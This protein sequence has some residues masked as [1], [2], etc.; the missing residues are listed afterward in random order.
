MDILAK[1]KITRKHLERRAA[2]YVRQSSMHQ[3][4][5]HTTS[6]QLQYDLCH[7][8]AS[9]GWP[10]EECVLYDADLGVS[11]SKPA[12]RQG[13]AQLVTDVALGSIGIIFAFDVTR[14][15][16]NNSDWHRLLD[17]CS[18]CGTLVADLDGIYDVAIYNDRLLLGL[19]GTM[20]EAEHHLIRTR[21]TE[22]MEQRA[23]EGALRKRL[24]VGLAYDPDGK[25]I[26]HPD[27]SIRHAV[28]LVFEKFRELGTAHQ[29]Y[30][31]FQ[32]EGL[33]LPVRRYKWDDIQ[34][35]RPNYD[36]IRDILAN[37]RYAG[38]YVYGRTK[39]VRSVDGHGNVR[40]TRAT[41]P[42][43][44]WKVMLPNHHAGYICW[45]DFEE[46]QKRMRKNVLMSRT[47]EAAEVLRN[48]RG[49]LQGL[50]RCGLCGRRMYTQYPAKGDGVRYVCQKRA[51]STDGEGVCQSF[52]GTRVEE[53]VVEA[54]FDALAPASVQLACKTL[55]RMAT[56]Q[57]AVLQQLQDQLAEARYQA[58]RA[59]RQYDAVEPENRNVART[60]ERAWNE[61]LQRVT[62][63]EAKIARKQQ[64]PPGQLSSEETKRLPTLGLDLRKVWQAPTTEPR[65][66]KRALQLAF[67]CVFARL[68]RATREVNVTLV[69]AGGITTHVGVR[70][71]GVG[72]HTNVTCEEIVNDVRTMAEAGMTDR[73]IANT[74]LRRGDR[75]ATGLPF[76]VARVRALRRKHAIAAAEGRDEPPGGESTLTAKQAAEALGVTIQT[77]LRW[78]HQGLL[79]GQQVTPLAPW[80]IH[81]PETLRF[82]SEESAPAGWLTLREA[83]EQLGGSCDEV[84]R[85]VL[86]GRLPAMLAGVGRQKRL[87]VNVSAVAASSPGP[88]FDRP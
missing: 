30:R 86:A 7:R 33:Q 39:I 18:L 17:M 77:V 16:R 1:T 78:L 65:D 11:G 26:L 10:R 66:R 50:M 27:E 81:L 12:Q 31:Y 40:E 19:K 76:S 71:P 56:Q 45:E 60:L 2:V 85:S 53:A 5:R 51:R 59:R 23:R 37:P 75:T 43:S 8:A 62:E 68:E 32:H 24:P 72:F 22:G 20:S 47:A 52:G 49:V 25:V 44:E 83:A 84:T 46:N 48:G 4:Q 79:R 34:W 36:A 9:F 88:L 80:R 64:M 74:F 63:L 70:V 87:R 38:A 41:M 82:P 35:G 15:A 73:Q 58:A 21:M 6:A 3:V 42:S 13:F 55:E 28:A 14:L 29:V 57:D 67:E 69:W 61:K 54:F